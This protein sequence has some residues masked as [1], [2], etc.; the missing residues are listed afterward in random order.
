MTELDFGSFLFL[1]CGAGLILGMLLA[2]NDEDPPN[3]P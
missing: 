3:H 2:W 1:I